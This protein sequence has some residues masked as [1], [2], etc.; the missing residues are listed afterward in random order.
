MKAW[1]SP[2]RMKTARSGVFVG[3][4]KHSFLG[5][6]LYH[7]WLSLDKSQRRAVQ[8]RPTCV[9]GIVL[10]AF[11][12]GAPLRNPGIQAGEVKRFGP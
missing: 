10:Y 1:P 12:I 8:E 7:S 11:F 4:S 2:R 3:I 9:N 6:Y 5:V